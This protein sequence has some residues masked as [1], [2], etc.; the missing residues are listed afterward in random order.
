MARVRLFALGG[1]TP[2]ALRKLTTRAPKAERRAEPSESRG[3]SALAAPQV[4]STGSQNAMW[5]APRKMQSSAMPLPGE[6]PSAIV[7]I[8]V[9]VASALADSAALT[10]SSE[11]PRRRSGGGWGASLATTEPRAANAPPPELTSDAPYEKTAQTP[12]GCAKAARSRAVRPP[13]EWPPTA[14]RV[15]S[16]RPH[17]GPPEAQSRARSSSRMAAIPSRL[18]PRLY[19]SRSPSAPMS[20]GIERRHVAVG[21]KGTTQEESATTHPARAIREASHM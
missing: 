6:T 13:E 9:S 7:R 1:S 20:N 21:P 19:S 18:G 11:P 2:R 10:P 14:R 4:G 5:F 8:R 16:M 17:R 12:N 3:R 15:R